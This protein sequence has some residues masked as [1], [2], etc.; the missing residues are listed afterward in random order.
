MKKVFV[1]ICVLED[2]RLHRAAL[3]CSTQTMTQDV[4][5]FVK[6]GWQTNALWP[7][8]FLLVSFWVCI[9]K[10]YLNIV[11]VQHLFLCHSGFV[12]VL[13]LWPPLSTKAEW[14]RPRWKFCNWRQIMQTW[15]GRW[16]WRWW[17]TWWGTCWGRW[18]GTWWG[19]W[20]GTWRG[21]WWGR[22]QTC[23]GRW[24][25]SRLERTQWEGSSKDK[26]GRE[27]SFSNLSLPPP[28]SL[29]LR[30]FWMFSSLLGLSR[31][32]TT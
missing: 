25:G 27:P 20:W 24:R 15:W 17:G 18:W 22:T 1:C 3:L 31:K 9:C 14:R 13:Y 5:S 29:Y 11:F 10:L 32:S 30:L 16:R 21:R 12:F 6:P 23:R 4:F 26:T 28:Q 2:C 19:R 7:C 8:C